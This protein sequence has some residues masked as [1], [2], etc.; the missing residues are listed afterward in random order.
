MKNKAAWYLYSSEEDRKSEKKKKR[1][2]KKKIQSFLKGM[3]R[4]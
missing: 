4:R 1:K 3:E 2:R